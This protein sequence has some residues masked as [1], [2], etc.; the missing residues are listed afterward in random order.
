LVSEKS[1]INLSA[2]VIP[3]P[4]ESLLGGEEPLIRLILSDDALAKDE[5]VLGVTL[6]YTFSLL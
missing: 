3:A 2:Q 4:Q 5:Y 1:T 6:N